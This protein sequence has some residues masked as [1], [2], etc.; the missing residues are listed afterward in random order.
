VVR[1]G[2]KKGKWME[3]EDNLLSHTVEV[4]RSQGKINWRIIAE[5]VPN[6]TSKQ[7]RERW[8][9]YISPE[10]R[11]DNFSNDE[12]RKLEALITK[13]GTK[14]SKIAKEMPGR[15]EN[16]VRARYQGLRIKL[17]RGLIGFK[18]SSSIA[19]DDN[20]FVVGILSTVSSSSTA[21]IIEEVPAS[22]MAAAA[23]GAHLH[24]TRFE[25]L[26]QRN[27]MTLQG[28][29]ELLQSMSQPLRWSM[30]GAHPQAMHHPM[31]AHPSPGMWPQNAY[32]S[33]YNPQMP[34]QLYPTLMSTAP[35]SHAWGA[36]APR[37]SDS[38]D[39][40]FGPGSLYPNGKLP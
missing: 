14:W 2:I 11:R 32:L 31:V 16:S 17:D 37:G 6:R 40:R 36:L 33:Y 39:P 3:E 22:S 13:Y 19:S 38:N 7:C 12:D 4:A 24:P 10:V 21:H 5:K 34:G 23:A 29:I 8:N 28:Q 9:H 25:D 26:A 30:F 18:Y 15:T 27:A 1:P 35:Y 20:L